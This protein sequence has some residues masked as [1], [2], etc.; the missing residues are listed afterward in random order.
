MNE[1]YLVLARKYRPA[2]FTDLKGQE[3]LVT[4]IVNSIK[5]NRIAHTFLLTG[6]RGSGKTTTARIIA[7]TLNCTNPVIDEKLVKPCGH[8]AN[9]QAAILGNHPD[10]IEL[11]AASRTGVNDI[12]EIIENTSYLPLLGKYKIYIIDEVHMLSTSAF[13]ALLKTLEEPPEHVKFIFATTELRKVPITII[14]RCQRFELRKLTLEQ[15]VEHLQTILDKEKITAEEDALYLIAQHAEG[16]VRDSLSLLD[17]VIANSN[18]DTITKEI[19]LN[20]LGLSNNEQIIAFL[21]DIAAGKVDAGIKAIKDFYYAG[22]DLVHIFQQLMALI[23]IISKIRLKI[24][25]AQFEYSDEEIARLEELAN[26]L[27]IENLTILWQMLVKAL[28]ELHQAHNIIISAE[29][30]VI[31]L[32]H[33]SNIPTPSAL[34]DKLE[35]STPLTPKALAQPSF[36]LV[37]NFEDLVQLFYQKREML[38]YQ[39]LVNDVY[40]IE[41]EPFKLKIRH[42]NSVP[43]NFAN[44]V[45]LFLKEWT[46]EKWNIIVSAEAGDPTISD[47]IESAKNEQIEHF[48][49]NDL[50]QEVLKNFS[51]A[52]IKEVT[53]K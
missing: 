4:T 49:K 40:L 13:N 6:I 17:L 12:R 46:G 35:S 5:L 26:N 21:E 42:T 52:A 28:H 50:V 48:M 45:A 41:F 19:V 14:S 8:C 33:L 15:S 31:R 16:S 29:M 43:H 36:D 23:H 9:C 22:K 37:H 27:N 30:L 51:S 1:N 44:K 47:Q 38:L 18:A 53:T 39:Y 25:I 11:D 3:F 2:D 10:I 7:K 24:N 34:I 32:C 20:L